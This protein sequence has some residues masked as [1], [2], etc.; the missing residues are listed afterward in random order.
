MVR[1]ELLLLGAVGLLRHGGEEVVPRPALEVLADA[2]RRAPEAGEV[3]VREQVLVLPLVHH[4]GAAHAVP[5]ALA[6]EVLAVVDALVVADRDA[7]VV[8]AVAVDDAGRGEVVGHDALAPPADVAD[9]RVGDVEPV[10]RT[11]VGQGGLLLGLL[12]ELDEQLDLPVDEGLPLDERV[13]L[14]LESLADTREVLVGGTREVARRVETPLFVGDS[15]VGEDAAGRR[16]VV[17]VAAGTAAGVLAPPAEVER[18]GPTRARERSG[19]DR[20][21]LPRPVPRKG[22][23]LGERRLLVALGD[24]DDRRRV[25]ALEEVHVLL[26]LLDV[27]ARGVGVRP[28]V[29]DHLA[30][31]D[32]AEEDDLVHVF[33]VDLDVPPLRDE[34][35]RPN[36]TV[37]VHLALLPRITL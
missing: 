24:L 9:E 18:G 34:V 31:R 35:L 23:D 37:G 14:L 2:L 30:N 32:L 17:V 10:V 7:A 20:L 11:L 33:P 8:V 13:T 12:L 16:D 22:S 25:L 36:R 21:L 6:V 29:P 28:P 27:A 26:H 15:G 3:G 1:K 4:L 5:A 19:I